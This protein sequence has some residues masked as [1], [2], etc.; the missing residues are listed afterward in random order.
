[1]LMKKRFI[2]SFVIIIPILIL[3]L[4]VVSNHFLHT[5][6]SSKENDY[7]LVQVTD[8]S[9]LEGQYYLNGDSNA[10]YFNI[11][12]DEIQFVSSS[13]QLK[14]FYATMIDNIN[15]YSSFDEEQYLSWS[16]T[17]EENWQ[18][19]MK[20]IFIHNTVHDN[21]TVSWNWNIDEDVIR[22]CEGAAY[23]DNMTISYGQCEFIRVS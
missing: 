2:I 11:V 7:P 6:G 14:E 12:S 17:I 5:S 9:L 15:Q 16:K 18:A 20:Y 3:L 19:P 10:C 1:M 21:I 23:I 13:T 8:I 22:S 4:I